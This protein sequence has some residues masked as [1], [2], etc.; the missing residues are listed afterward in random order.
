MARGGAVFA[1][2][3]KY[4]TPTIAIR[5]RVGAFMFHTIATHMEKSID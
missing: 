2:A 4:K 3:E 5:I 1:V